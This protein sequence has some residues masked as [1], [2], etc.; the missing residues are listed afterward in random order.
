MSCPRS[1]SI[2]RSCP[3]SVGH[4]ALGGGFGRHPASF[5]QHVTDDSRTDAPLREDE[6]PDAPPDDLVTRLERVF[7]VP[8][9]DTGMAVRFEPQPEAL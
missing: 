5:A 2:P 9:G 1:S 3:N 8:I 4:R 7:E 6:Q